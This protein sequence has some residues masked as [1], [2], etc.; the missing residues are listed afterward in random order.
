MYIEELAQL[1]QEKLALLRDQ[2]IERAERF[3]AS[4]PVMKSGYFQATTFDVVA[5]DFQYKSKRAL[6][7]AFAFV[8]GGMIGVAYVLIA[9]A[10]HG[11]NEAEPG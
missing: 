10:M 3:F 1:E 6:M 5:T 7:L 4:T 11:S 8:V 9:N 2:T